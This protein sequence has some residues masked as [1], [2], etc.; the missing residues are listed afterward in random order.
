MVGMPGREEGCKESKGWVDN[1]A[2]PAEACPL[3]ATPLLQRH[4]DVP[5]QNELNQLLLPSSPKHQRTC[6]D[7]K[8]KYFR[9]LG[10]EY[11]SGLIGF[12]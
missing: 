5:R 8:K 4:D 6:A 7:G 1:I 12:V 11:I 10:F 2:T 3:K 9:R